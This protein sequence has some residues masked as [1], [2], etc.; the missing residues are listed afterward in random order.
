MI[1]VG[2]IM[3]RNRYETNE[4][5]TYGDHAEILLYNKGCNEIARAIID[6]DDIKLI[7]EYQW[8]IQDKHH[9]SAKIND[10]TTYLHRMIMNCPDGM[11]IDHINHN[12]LD[13]RKQNL[14]ICTRAENEHNKTIGKNNTS[15]HLG[16][17]WNKARQKWRVVLGFNKKTYHLGE[18]DDIEEAIA[19][20]KAAEKKYYGEF[21]Y[22]EAYYS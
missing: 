16:V 8:H 6:I 11:F 2:K 14:R 10:K 12:P 4:I 9:V 3:T 1:S 7:K 15:G 21:A 18:Y 17:I 19:V 22:K 20:R 5:I 13:N